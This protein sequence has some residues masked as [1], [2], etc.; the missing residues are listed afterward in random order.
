MRSEHTC[1]GGSS[2]C[3]ACIRQGRVKALLA[4]AK[5]HLGEATELTKKSPGR[6]DAIIAH[7]D[8]YSHCR[9]EASK[10]EAGHD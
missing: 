7:S 8:S 1:G 5:W 9:A 3:P 10:L 2:D 6:V 4:L